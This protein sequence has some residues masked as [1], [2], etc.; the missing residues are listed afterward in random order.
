MPHSSMVTCTVDGAEYYSDATA[1]ARL[2]HAG[3][4]FRLKLDASVDPPGNHVEF[5]YGWENGRHAPLLTRNDG[6]ATVFFDYE[7]R[8][9]P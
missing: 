9:D 6:A 4:I 2:G 3:D 1:D 7:A 5:I 8:P